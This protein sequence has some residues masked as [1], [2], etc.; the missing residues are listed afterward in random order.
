MGKKPIFYFIFSLLHRGL[1]LPSPHLEWFLGKYLNHKVSDRKHFGRQ[2]DLK[3]LECSRYF[4]LNDIDE[5]IK[6]DSVTF[7]IRFLNKSLELKVI[8]VKKLI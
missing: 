5:K 8:E 2:C 4:T 3:V 6:N 1:K 7:D